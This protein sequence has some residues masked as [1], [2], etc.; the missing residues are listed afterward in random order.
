MY[1]KIKNSKAISDIEY[2]LTVFIDVYVMLILGYAALVLAG[3][4]PAIDLSRK[5]LVVSLALFAI[6]RLVV[7][8]SRGHRKV[9]K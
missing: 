7:A 4:L 1:N 8:V 9:V 5:V 2:G 6:I 3:L